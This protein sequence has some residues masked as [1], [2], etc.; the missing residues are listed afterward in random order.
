MRASLR[1]GGLALAFLVLGTACQSGA[2][3]GATCT[4][5]SECASPLTC[6]FGRCRTECA[7]H[8]DCPPGAL[9]LLDPSGAGRCALPDDPDCRRA[10][11]TCAAGLACIGGECVNACSA[12]AECPPDSTCTPDPVD[13][14]ARCVPLP[15]LDAGA[16]GDAGIDAG[17]P[18]DAAQT[19]DAGCAGPSCDPVVQIGAGE[20]YACARTLSGAVWCWGAEANLGTGTSSAVCDADEPCLRAPGRVRVDLG[21]GAGPEDLVADSLEVN[22]ENA[23]ALVGGDIV[24]W[25]DTINGSLGTTG[26]GEIA[27]PIRLAPGGTSAPHD[28]TAVA[29]LAVAGIGMRATGSWYGWGDDTFGAYRGDGATHPLAVTATPLA[30]ATQMIGGLDHTCAVVAG[31]A[32]CWGGNENGES[33][34][35]AV[36]LGAFTAPVGVVGVPTGV[37][38]LQVGR[39]HS[40]ALVVDTGGASS[41]WCWGNRA[42]LGVAS[43][44]AGCRVG[45]DRTACPAVEVALD[46]SHTWVALAR[47]PYT[48]ATCAIDAGG[49]VWCWGEDPNGLF[50][51]LSGDGL[52]HPQAELSGVRALALGPSFGCAI[53]AGDVRCWGSN[54]LGQLGR[55]NT[56][57][58]VFD[59]MPAPVLWP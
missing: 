11:A 18:N 15:A 16:T 39:A 32:W 48:N 56:D 50:T 52:P 53:V 13:G 12:V 38:D 40:C 27:R 59:P 43:D 9:C 1:R 36:G 23:C 51:D 28:F 3:I 44:P 5:P 6:A 47:G 30:A 4:R 33:G 41:V 8:R 55:G 14:L 57:G 20:S 31:D 46:P 19:P 22:Q 49:A 21:L 58:S 26:T 45:G 54:W 7:A 25:G 37:H 2:P 17:A 42:V 35:A 34:A 10:G 29:V 24:C